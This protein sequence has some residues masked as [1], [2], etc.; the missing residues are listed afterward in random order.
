MKWRFIIFIALVLLLGNVQNYKELTDLAIVSCI[1]IDSLENGMYN[2][3]VQVVNSKKSSGGKEEGG[4]DSEVTI[5]KSKAKTIQEALRLITKESPKKLHLANLELLVISEEVAK[6]GIEKVLDFFLRNTDVNNE[7]MLVLSKKGSTAEKVISI[8]TPIEKNPTL[9]LKN[10]LE[11]FADKEGGAVKTTASYALD[12]IMKEYKDV[13]ITSVTI[14]GE[15]EDGEKA[16]NIKESDVKTKVIISDVAF[17]V[18]GTFRGYLSLE[19]TIVYNIIANDLKNSI[20][21]TKVN[22]SDAAFE[23]VGSKCKTSVEMKNDKFNVDLVIDINANLSEIKEE[24]NTNEISNIKLL[25]NALKSKIEQMVKNYLEK[26][27][28]EYKVDVCGFGEKFYKKYGNKFKDV[29]EGYIDKLRF[30]VTVKTA[31]E[32]EGSE[33]ITR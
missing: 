25:E 9:S 33:L 27:I 14:V 17:F 12:E 6:S 16:D 2:V 28:K 26:N 29:S 21:S 11:T 15:N 20:I 19:D 5:Y 31:L 23:I 24:L 10:S 3:S 13:V 8:L 18:G 7:F 1:G 22:E 32:N 30:R 4:N